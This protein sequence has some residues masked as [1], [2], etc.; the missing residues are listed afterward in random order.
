MT[1]VLIIDRDRDF[2]RQTNT[3]LTK[4]G[5]KCY[6]ATTGQR[7]IEIL[8]QHSIDLVLCNLNLK[9]ESSVE[10]IAKVKE[11]HPEMP[12]IVVTSFN[13]VRSA[14][15]MMKCG[16]SDYLVKPLITSELIFAINARLSEQCGFVH[17]TIVP[18]DEPAPAR[19]KYVFSNSEFFQKTLDQI[20]LVAPTDYSVIIYGE[21]GSGKEAFAQE[22]HK[23]SKRRV[24]PFLAIDCG[25]LPRELSSSILFGYEKGAFT[26]A[27]TTRKGAFEE[28]LGGTVFLDE[29]SN[30]P[31]EIQATLL[32]VLQ[33]KTIR[34]VGGT[35]DI[36][37]DVRI[38]VASNEQLW[39]ACGK[40]K[41]R[42]DLYHRFNEFAITVDPLR[43]R[44]EDILFYAKLFIAQS[45]HELGKRVNGFT[46]DALAAVLDYRWPGNLRELRNFIRRSVLLTESD[47]IGTAV[48]PREFRHEPVYIASLNRR[49][50]RHNNVLKS[51]AITSA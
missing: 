9:K 17:T 36:A 6:D 44:K 26:G 8:R 5:F 48:L 29:V 49:A 21:S 39:Q 32:R 41:F 50:G 10:L 46:E 3:T 30:L 1:I 28:A 34:R 51:P 42:E 31:L 2:L 19:E 27:M 15:N 7:G 4:A 47:V 16:A 18:A 23:R 20:S 45:N 11:D 33:E 38:I 37:V 14:V 22:I 13:N 25:A 12:V 24:K 43:E 40:G 35:D